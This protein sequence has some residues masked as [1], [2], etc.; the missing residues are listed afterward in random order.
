MVAM[1]VTPAVMPVAIDIA[2]VLLA[3][4]AL[5]TMVAVAIVTIV[6]LAVPLMLFVVPGLVMV[7]IITVVA[8]V[9]LQE[10]FLLARRQGI[11]PL[12]VLLPAVTT[13]VIVV[14]HH[15]SRCHQECRY[16]ASDQQSLHDDSPVL[17]RDRSRIRTQC[18]MPLNPD[19]RSGSECQCLG[20]GFAGSLRKAPSA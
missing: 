12:M 11:A 7:P 3:P 9:G 1:P 18:R 4:M 10:L 17:L 6:V 20:A 13:A 19:Y 8:V 5:V 2:L 15:R 16:Q 14:G